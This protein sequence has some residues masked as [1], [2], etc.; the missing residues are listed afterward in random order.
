M[1]AVL[2][3][4]Q[5]APTPSYV[6]P[7][8]YTAKRAADCSII[9]CQSFPVGEKITPETAHEIALRF[10]SESEKL[11]VYEIVVSTHCDRDH[12]H[13]HFVMNSVNA[14]TG[15]KFH[16]NEN[17]V[18]MLMK[19]SDVIVQQ[20]G[21]FVLSP[22]PKKQKVKPMSDR[23]YR[24][25]DIGQS[26]KLRLTMVIDDVMIQAISREHFIELMELESYSV[27]WTDERKYITYTTPDGF[28]CRDNKLH[29][30]KYLK[31]NM[32]NEFRIRK[33]IT[34]GIER[35]GQ[36]ADTNSGESRAVYRGY[37]A[38]LESDDWLTEN[39]D[40]YAVRDTGKS[41]TTYHPFGTDEDTL[42][43]ERYA[44][45]IYRGYGNTDNGIS[46]ADGTAGVSIYRTDEYGNAEYVLTG[47]E[48]ERA[49]FE[50]SLYCRGQDEEV[51]N[52][53][54][55]DFSDT[56]SYFNHLGTDTAFL[57]AELTYILD[58]TP[59]VE[60]CTTMKQPQQKKKKEQNHGP[61]MGGM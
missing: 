50:E 13:S 11:K 15:K 3:V 39:A 44:D 58:S 57:V 5:P 48:N 29:E 27:K 55:L 26:W 25:A 14:E 21:L 56:D 17:E 12:I 23:E 9:L 38:E 30:E 16:I 34:T 18:E 36:T 1:S 7:K 53:S 4:S 51:F 2:T 47:W 22:Q 61:V 19:E 42:T 33:E 43:A 37:R 32:E 10:A 59:Y 31:G 60:D 54:I 41:G 46:G 8:S 45:E 40:G 52:Q 49:I 28:K 6:I 24:S 20:C 35:A